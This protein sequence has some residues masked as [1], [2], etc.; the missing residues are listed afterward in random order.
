MQS[1][2]RV[3]DSPD[4]PS[5]SA[6]ASGGAELDAAPAD[7][8]ADACRGTSAANAENRMIGSVAAPRIEDRVR[9]NDR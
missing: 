8:C 6:G 1:A 7:V 2:A 9:S 5:C 4:P 3:Q